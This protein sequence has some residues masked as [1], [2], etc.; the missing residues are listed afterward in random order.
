MGQVN[1]A[2]AEREMEIGGAAFVVM[3]VDVL[4]A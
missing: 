4:E 3:E 1:G 2:G